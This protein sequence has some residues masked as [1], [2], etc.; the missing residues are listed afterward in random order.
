MVKR[1]RF[2]ATHNKDGSRKGGGR[3]GGGGGGAKGGTKGYGKRKIAELQAKVEEMEAT[4]EEERAAQGSR[5]DE[6]A[7]AGGKRRS[8][9]GN[10]ALEAHGGTRQLVKYKD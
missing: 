8:N 9:T 10:P 1:K 6:G 4:L 5:N 2:L 3:P 7:S